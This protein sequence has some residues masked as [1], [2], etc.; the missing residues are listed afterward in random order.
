MAKAL[1]RR[2]AQT[3]L[4]LVLVLRLV[5]PLLVHLLPSLSP[6]LHLQHLGPKG[7]NRKAC[8]HFT[9]QIP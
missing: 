3:L 4:V 7:V 2:L 5:S 8:Q 9:A 1:I 6:F